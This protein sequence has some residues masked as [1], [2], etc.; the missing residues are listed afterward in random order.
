[1]PLNY[2][3]VMAQ[4]PIEQ[5]SVLTKR[6]VILYALGV[7]AGADDPLSPTSLRYLYE[8]GLQVLPTMA[9]VIG[10]P[11][12]WLRDARYGVDWKRLLHGEQSVEIHRPLPAEGAVS[13]RLIIEEI[14][15]KGVEKGAI[16]VS[17]RELFDADGLLLATLRSTAYLRGDG[18]CGGPSRAPP[19]PHSVPEHRQPD[20]TADVCTRKD[21][22]LLYRLSGDYNPLHVDPA[23][24]QAAGFDVPILHGLCTFGIVGRVLLSSLCRDDSHAFEML[25]VRFSSPVFPGETLRVQLWR[26]GPGTASVRVYA[27]E[28][29]VRVIDNGLFRFRANAS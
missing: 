1:M 12:F 2:Q 29:N 18:G 11:G 19:K 4:P 3:Q 6:D 23:V 24:A 9:V 21:Q 27:A 15:D 20:I 14:F 16:L 17:K 8:T 28:R 7:G 22:A 10:S 13:S 5:R 25:A 26:D